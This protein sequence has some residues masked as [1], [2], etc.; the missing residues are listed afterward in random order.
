M[1]LT[2]IAT[3]EKN[4]KQR[5]KLAEQKRINHGRA[6]AELYEDIQEAQARLRKAH[7]EAGML[8]E[9]LGDL[10]YLQMQQQFSD[11]SDSFAMDGPSEHQ[12]SHV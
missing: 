4:L 11:D 5:E 7:A 6:I 2:D 10:Q 1:L 3:K 8:N 12:Y 9:E